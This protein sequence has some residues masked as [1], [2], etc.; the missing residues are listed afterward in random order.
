VRIS[1]EPDDPDGVPVGVR[2]EV[3]G[4]AGTERVT[5]SVCGFTLKLSAGSDVVLTCGSVVVE[6]ISGP[7]EVELGGGLA[8]VI[9]PDGSK[10]VVDS[11]PSGAFTVDVG[12]GSVTVNVDGVVTTLDAA[13]PVATIRTW[14]F[15]GF[16]QPVDGGATTNSVKA[17]RAVPLKWR[18]LDETGAPV[19]DL[20]SVELTFQRM[21]CDGS[22]VDPVE[23]TVTVGSGLQNNGDGRYQLNWKTPSTRGCGTLQLDIGDGVLH[24]AKFRLT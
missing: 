11:T 4:V 5:L 18:L 19:L 24:T 9:I 8:V 21:S 12:E 17:G 14:D 6:V 22:A 2:I 16:E 20:T 1:D 13:D 3:V 23:Q 15:V 10:A 7:V